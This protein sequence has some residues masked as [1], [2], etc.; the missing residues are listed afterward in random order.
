MASARK[1]IRAKI[2]EI[3]ILKKVIQTIFLANY[4][5]EIARIL[6]PNFEFVLKVREN[7]FERKLVRIRYIDHSNFGSFNDIEIANNRIMTVLSVHKGEIEA[8]K[9]CQYLLDIVSKMTFLDFDAR[10][11]AKW[12]WV[13]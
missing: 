12:S 1:L 6:V 9:W 7:F 4:L 13:V 5:R 10:L 3:H 2:F 8:S 11:P